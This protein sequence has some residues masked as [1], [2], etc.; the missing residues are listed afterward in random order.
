MSTRL[1]KVFCAIVLSAL[2]VQAYGQSQD[3]SRMKTIQTQLNTIAAAFDRLPAKHKSLVDGYGRVLSLQKVIN[4]LAAQSP[5]I[6]QTDV[7]AAL[8]AD[9][10]FSQEERGTTAVNDRSTDQ[11]FSGFEGITQSETSTAL[12]VNQAAVGFN[13]SGSELQSFFFGTGGLSFSGAAVSSDRG[14][15]FQDIGLVNPGPNFSTFLLGDPVL[16]CSDPNTFYYSQLVTGSTSS[17]ST[18]VALSHSTDG[19]NTWND[20]VTAVSKDNRTH[21]LDKSWH[22]IDPSNPAR[23]YIS[24]TD[25]DSS[26]TSAACPNQVRV[27]IEV[28]VSNDAGQTFGSP[29][30]IDDAC[31]SDSAVQA[32]HVAVSSHGKVYVAWERFNPTNVELRFTSFVPG[33]NPAPSV[34]VDQIVQGGAVIEEFDA[35]VALLLQGEFRDLVGIDLAVDRSHGPTDGNVYVVWDD[36]RNKSVPEFFSIF[37]NGTYNFTD[38]LFSRSTD[39]QHFSAATRVNSDRQPTV[40]SGH[41]HFQPALAVDASGSVAACWYD[42]RNDQENFQIE[43]FCALSGNAGHQWAEHRVER[44]QFAPLHGVDDLTNPNY[45]GDYDGLTSDFTGATR[46]FLGAF[47]V[48]TSGLNPDVKAHRF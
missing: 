34:V 22:A 4:R 19:G 25:F 21:F 29:I 38:V 11:Q 41:D 33:Q 43:R 3:P 27:G 28:V 13:D 8:A 35:N 30:V 5:R 32:S 1:Y 37:P 10:A 48:L 47:Q 15:T 17:T 31:G 45:M 20:P 16:S 7:R 23:I 12:C 39:G 42:R 18:G 44:T 6:S 36:G 24:Y 40:G 2:T 26:G 46:G 9:A 14:K